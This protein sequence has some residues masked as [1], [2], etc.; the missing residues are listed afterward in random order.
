[1]SDNNSAIVSKVW[2][3]WNTPLRGEIHSRKFYRKDAKAA[4]KYIY[5]K[6]AKVQR[7]SG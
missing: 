4:K 1:M 5:R 3:F 6:D 7:L 2:S